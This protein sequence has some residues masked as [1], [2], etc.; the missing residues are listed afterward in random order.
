MNEPF[1]CYFFAEHMGKTENLVRIVYMLLYCVMKHAELW[2]LKLETT[3]LPGPHFWGEFLVM[4]RNV[5]KSINSID[6]YSIGCSSVSLGQH[7]ILRTNVAFCLEKLGQENQQKVFQSSASASFSSSSFRDSTYLTARRIRGDR[8][9]GERSKRF[10]SETSRRLRTIKRNP[11]G[12][13]L[14]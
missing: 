6:R 10:D 12:H 11:Y 3:W 14:C 4:F 2:W 7:P 5:N 9:I 8:W 13:T 1:L